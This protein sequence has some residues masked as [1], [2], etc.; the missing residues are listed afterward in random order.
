MLTVVEVAKRMGVSVALVYSLVESGAL[1]HYRIGNPG[2]RGA[3]RISEEQLATFLL[4]RMK[5]SETTKEPPPSRV[6]ASKGRKIKLD[7]ISL[8]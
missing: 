3:V 6:A 2:K 4:S 5:G 8:P 1:P 7:H